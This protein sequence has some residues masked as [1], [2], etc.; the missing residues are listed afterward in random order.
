MGTHARIGKDAAMDAVS[1]VINLG[2]A[3]GLTVGAAL[4]LV[5]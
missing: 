4:L 1:F 2:F 3:L 5:V